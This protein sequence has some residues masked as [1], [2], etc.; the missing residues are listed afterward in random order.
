MTVLCNN[1]GMSGLLEKVKD[2]I[3][4]D[5]FSDVELA[6]LLAG[7]DFSRHALVKRAMAKGQLIQIRRGLYC[8]SDKYRKKPLNLLSLAQKI[9]G[10]SYITLESALS[11]HGWIPE[12]VF[13]VTSASALRS[14]EFK[15]SLGVFGFTR[16][17]ADPFLAGVNLQSGDGDSFFIAGPWRALADYVYVHKKE[18]KDRKPLRE[19]LRIEDE[20]L[21]KTDLR[22]LEEIEAA[23][24]SRR[25]RKFLKGIAKEGR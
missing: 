7:T 10:P 8:L 5:C 19:S 11:Y 21:Q 22:E 9:Y 24:R 13:A 2:Q 17:P 14:R 1:K 4:Y 6:N 18:W 12:A 25:V 15:T 23:F 16:I 3:P 20:H